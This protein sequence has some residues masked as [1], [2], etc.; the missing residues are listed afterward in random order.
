[1]HRSF[2]ARLSEFEAIRAAIDEFAAQT[3]I[4]GEDC[5][6]LVVIAEELF[7]NSV[8][9]GYGVECDRPVWISLQC[10]ASALELRF[11]DEAPEF[12]PIAR[13]PR[14]PLEGNPDARPVGGLGVFLALAMSRDARYRRE[15]GRNI[16]EFTFARSDNVA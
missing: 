10:V 15:D 7:V 12:D 16:I 11:E 4:C 1:M 14:A 6:R 13:A 5:H 9:H 3:G 8:R 2:P